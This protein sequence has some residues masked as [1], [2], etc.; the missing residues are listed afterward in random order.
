LIAQHGIADLPFQR[1]CAT[2]IEES[3]ARGE[4]PLAQL[5]FLVDRI[6]YFA[7]KPQIYGTQFYGMGMKM[8]K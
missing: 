8:A 7:G 5:A 1:A 4:A 3:I 2:A 6:R